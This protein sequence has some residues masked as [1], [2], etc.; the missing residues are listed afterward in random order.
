MA[1][2]ALVRTSGRAPRPPSASLTAPACAHGFALPFAQGAPRR[3]GGGPTDK[4][5]AISHAEHAGPGR[6]TTVDK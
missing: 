4:S 3:G 2:P 6:T 1:S 5:S